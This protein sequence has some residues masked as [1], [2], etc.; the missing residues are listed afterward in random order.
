MTQP[1]APFYVPRPADDTYWSGSP[2]KS[3]IIQ[4]LTAGG[5]PP[6]PRF[7]K[8]DVD[9]PLP[10]PWRPLQSQILSILLT[11]VGKPP[12]PRYDLDIPDDPLWQRTTILNQ[13]IAF[14]SEPSP[15][16]PPLWKY[17]LDDP[18]MWSWQAPHS[19]LL[20]PILTSVRPRFNEWAWK[21]TYEEP[22]IWRQPPQ[23][24]VLV[25]F[26]S[27]PGLTIIKVMPWGLIY[28]SDDF[29]VW[30]QQ[31]RQL[32]P[33][34]TPPAPAVVP[35]LAFASDQSAYS[36]S[37]SDSPSG[38]NWSGAGFMAK[39][40]IDTTVQINGDFINA[41]T[42]VYVDPSLVTLYLLTPAGVGSSVDYPGAVS[43]SSQGH[44][45][46]QITASQSGVWNYKWQASGTA[47]AT[48]PD[49]SF[50]VNAS[51]LIAG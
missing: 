39:Y 45:F 51:L 23:G 17:N 40:E 24:L 20:A 46:Y 18:Q 32:G 33:Q 12:T 1:V 50:T 19:S 31:I 2:A 9:E 10:S 8:Y 6:I 35:A 28:S 16:K 36:A 27:P 48:S 43:R 25:P 7:W 38:Q 29:P 3:P 44:Y 37:G 42:G 15:F 5:K 4:F 41:I 49:G 34:F 14:L 47:V 13:A 22:A 11:A 21:S 26:P 30:Y